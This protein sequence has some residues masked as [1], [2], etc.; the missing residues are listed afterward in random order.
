MKNEQQVVFEKT[1]KILSDFLKIKPNE[2]IMSSRLKMDLGMDSVDSIDISAELE[3][4]FQI[5]IDDEEAASSVRGGSEMIL[6][7][8]YAVQVSSPKIHD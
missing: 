5:H 1:R 3:K 7:S 8:P 6:D 4:E 2:I